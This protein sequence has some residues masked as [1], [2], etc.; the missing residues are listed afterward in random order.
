[1]EQQTLPTMRPKYRPPKIITIGTASVLANIRPRAHDKL[2][3]VCVSKDG[4]AG[5]VLMSEEQAR[6]L[7]KTLTELV[8]EL[9]TINKQCLSKQTAA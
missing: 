3:L 1:M 9:S 8:D 7:I 5:G 6:G 4:E 2:E